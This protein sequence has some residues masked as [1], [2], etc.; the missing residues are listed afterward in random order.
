MDANARQTLE[1]SLNFVIF[2]YKSKSVFHTHL[3]VKTWKCHV[4]NSYENHS[5]KLNIQIVY[6]Y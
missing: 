5:S 1:C 4:R 6:L 2:S 3:C